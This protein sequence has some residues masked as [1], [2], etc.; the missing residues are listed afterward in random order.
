MA[1]VTDTSTPS[2][3]SGR[4]RQKILWCVALAAVLLVCLG[5][6]FLSSGEGGRVYPVYI[7][8]VLASNTRLPN[9]DGRCCD[10]IELYNSADYPV[11]LSGF[12]LGDIAGSSRYTFP[13]GTV[14]DGHGYLVVYCD[15][16][17]EEPGYAHFG[18]SRS[19]NETFYLIASNGAVVDRMTTLPTELDQT[20]I[21]GEDGQWILADAATPGAAPYDS[22]P[23]GEDTWNPELSPVRITEYSSLDNVCHPGTGLLS[24]WVELHNTGSDPADISGFVLSDNVNNDKYTFPQGTVLPAGSYLLVCCAD[25]EGEDLAPFHLSARVSESIVLKDAQGRIVEMLWTCPME[26]FGS[27]ALTES[28]WSATNT[29]TPGCENTQAG[30][31]ASL[32]AIGADAG[33]IVISE[34]MAATQYVIP[35]CFGEFSDWAELYNAGDTAVEL[36]GWFLSDDPNTPAKWQLPSL[37]IQPGERRILFL[38]GRDGVY[39]DEIHAGFSLSASGESLILTSS[40]GTV[41]DS[42]TFGPSDAGQSFVMDSGEPVLCDDPTPGYPNDQA[43]YEAFCDAN[44]PQGPLA[45][46]EVMTSND[47]YLPQALGKCYDWVELRNV[48]DGNIRLSDFS[49]TDDEGVPAQYV[50]PDKTLAPGQCIVIILSGNTSLSTGLYSHAPFSLNAAQDQLLLYQGDRLVDY[51]SLRNIP[52]RHS[53]GRSGDQGG[54]S[55]MTPTPGTENI[56]GNRQISAV[57]TSAMGPGVFTSDTSLSVPLSAEGT[58]YYTLDGSDPDT[59]SPVYSGPIEINSTTVLR[60]AALEDGKM[61]SGIYTATFIIQE[62]HSIPVVSLVTDPDNLWGPNGIYKYGDITI[63]EEK[64]TANVSYTGSDGS[65]SLDCEISL[66]GA[67]TVT[68]WEKKSFT[69][70]FQDNYDGPL[71]Y[72]VFEDGE[73]TVFSSLI[74]RAAHESTFSTHLRDALMGS[75]A[76]ESCDTLVSQK[77]K[78]VALYLN[79]EYWGLYALREQHTAEHYGFYMG[80]PADTVVKYRYCISGNNQLHDLY[81]SLDTTNLSIPSNYEY[82]KTFLDMTSFADWIIFQSYTGNVDVNGNMRYYYSSA[83]GLWRC[84]LVDLDLGMFGENGFGEIMDTFHHGELVTALLSNAEFR[85]LVSRRMAELLEGPLSDESIA[86]KIDSMCD[87]IRDE[88]VLE[89]A[90]WGYTSE[91]WESAVQKL[92]KYCDGGAER[93]LESYFSHVGVPMADRERYFGNLLHKTT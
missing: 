91:L 69:V 63:R 3:F 86:A 53:Y 84:G 56:P 40:L 93:V 67:T 19:G 2:G 31:E 24:D 61:L 9:A 66:H 71:Y 51:A 75:I 58:I 78:Y 20:M 1:N 10:Y 44:Q 72:D 55:Y 12:L 70:R 32:A 13:Q 64:R 68:A 35:D 39:E 27:M 42:V 77:Y 82:A 18:I 59:Q 80:V 17:V 81:S 7:T 25:G 54:F 33:H 41:V 88:I 92:R 36:A 60:A 79:G 74:V 87:E 14:L 28:G 8:E 30:Y 90:R 45:I 16:A 5:M 89:S 62:P 76:S 46:W 49:I 22:A 37:T 85:D 47:W 15:A 43:G 83:D 29:P 50:L 52:L 65:F 73:A 48:S 6:I 11:D 23:S 34:L 26:A 21:L 4:S 57:P 38:S